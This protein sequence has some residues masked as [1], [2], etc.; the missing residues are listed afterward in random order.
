MHMHII[1]SQLSPYLRTPTSLF[2]NYRTA[3]AV[4]DSMLIK[5]SNSIDRCVIRSGDLSG[6]IAVVR[7]PEEEKT[8]ENYTSSELHPNPGTPPSQLLLWRS[9]QHGTTPVPHKS[10]IF[11]SCT[12]IR[13]RGSVDWGTVNF[14]LKYIVGIALVWILAVSIV[15]R[16]AIL[17]RTI[18]TCNNLAG[19]QRSRS[20]SKLAALTYLYSSTHK[21]GAFLL[22]YPVI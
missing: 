13:T 11:R 5:H 9:I 15:E 10:T 7:M 6:P 3:H 8:D 1:V 21:R 16:G 2:S 14:T 20:S 12:I 19:Y 18:I 4:V 17:Q 22:V